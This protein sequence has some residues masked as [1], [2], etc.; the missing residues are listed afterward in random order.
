[1]TVNSIKKIK[2]IDSEEWTVIGDFITYI[3]N[4]VR[5]IVN[6]NLKILDYYESEDFQKIKATCDV[7]MSSQREFNEYINEKVQSISKLFGTRVV[8]NE[9]VVDD[10]TIIFVLTKKQLHHLLQ[11]YRQQC[12]QVLKTVHWSMW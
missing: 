3:E 5:K 12:L 1:M 9:T 2:S 10:Q 8:R 7:M 4:E 11:R 6:E